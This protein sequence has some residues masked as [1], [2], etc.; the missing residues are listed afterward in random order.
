VTRVNTDHPANDRLGQAEQAQTHESSLFGEPRPRLSRLSN[1]CGMR[2]RE[3]DSGSEQ[4]IRWSDLIG[5]LDHE[6]GCRVDQAFGGFSQD[7]SD[8]ARQALIG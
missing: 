7:G 3:V 5:G 6:A 8:G 2:L 4:V 1:I